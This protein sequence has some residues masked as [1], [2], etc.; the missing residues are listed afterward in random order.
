MPPPPTYETP[1]SQ[2][3][4]DQDASPAP[5][6]RQ[7]APP[8]PLPF[9]QPG[10]SPSPLFCDKTG[11]ADIPCAQMPCDYNPQ[12]CTRPFDPLC[13][14]PDP[15]GKFLPFGMVG[16]KPGNQRVI[17]LGE[18]FVP[19]WQDAESLLFADFSGEWDDTVAGTGFFGLGYRTFVDPCWIFGL[20]GYYDLLATNQSNVFNQANLGIELMSLNWDFRVN[21]YFPASGGKSA[22]TYGGISNGTVVTN[23][24]VERAYGGFDFEIGNRFLYWGWNDRYQLH[25]FLGAYYFENKAPSFAGPKARLEMRMFDLG[26]LGEQSR[27]ELGMEVLADHVRNEQVYGYLRVRIP[28][29]GKSGRALLDPLRRRMVDT[30][31][32]PI[33]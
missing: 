10:S 26:W 29:G 31:V 21:G 12:D 24:F 3:P 25:W 30:I 5:S 14:Q 8:A 19:V 13:P 32:H 23:N 11:C 17:G 28:F 7:I 4:A 20:Y 22:I 1:L 18:V 33:D 6:Q 15:C 16:V 9:D 2:S 27:V